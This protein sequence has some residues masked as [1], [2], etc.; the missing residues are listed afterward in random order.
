MRTPKIQHTLIKNKK[1]TYFKY[2]FETRQRLWPKNDL[3][4]FAT[5]KYDLEYCTNLELE[6]NIL[7]VSKR[8]IHFSKLFHGLPKSS[9][10]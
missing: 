6:G 5:R 7:F 2:K 9:L 3:A 10:K 1:F 4:I 8:K